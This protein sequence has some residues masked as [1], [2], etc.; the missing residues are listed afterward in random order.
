[1]GFA[2]HSGAIRP[3]AAFDDPFG[4]VESLAFGEVVGINAL[5]L[6]D[7]SDRDA[8]VVLDHEFHQLVAVDEDD[9]AVADA[10][11]EL[12][13]ILGEGG[14]RDEDA[15]GGLLPARAPANCCTSVQPTVNS[16]FFTK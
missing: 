5:H 8:D 11:C 7:L 13:G 16:R 14:V 4:I 10:L 3:L 2:S 6:I 1:V 12:D 9:L 15:F